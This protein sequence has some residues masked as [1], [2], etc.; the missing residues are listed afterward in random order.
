M[1]RYI[2]IFYTLFFTHDIYAQEDHCNSLGVWLWHLE[3]TNYPSYVN[4]ANDLDSLGVKRIYI[5]VAD[6]G[7]DS[8]RWPEIVNRDIINIF[9]SKGIEPWAWS[10]N[11]PGNEDRQAEALYIAA[12]TG[13]HGFVID[14][15]SEFDGETATLQNL[16]SSFF[17]ARNQAINDDIITDSLPLYVTTWGNPQDH[18]FHIELLDPYVD[19]YMPQTYLEKWGEDYLDNPEFWINI[20]N[21][22]YKALGATKPIHH[23]LSME[24]GTVTA[25]IVNRFFQH[26]GPMSTIWRI[27]GGGTPL[28][29]RDVWNDV[30]WDYNYCE[31]TSTTDVNYSD[32]SVFPVPFSADLT[33]HAPLDSQVEVYTICGHQI[34][35]KSV[36]DGHLYIHTDSWQRGQ[37]VIKVVSAGNVITQTIIKI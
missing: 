31:V 5:K 16:A 12:S 34:I 11:Y 4:L 17:R 10:Y 2:I 23:I 9:T 20:G 21:Q 22:E 27:P 3:A 13:Y 29:I 37:F 24:H 19:A 33:V 7:V 1:L 18:N 28:L 25:D 15:E 14:L 6:G 35:K 26:S 30:Q 36:S 32:I 8:V